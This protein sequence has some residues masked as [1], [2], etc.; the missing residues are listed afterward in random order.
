[1]P[2]GVQ[3]ATAAAAPVAQWAWMPIAAMIAPV[4]LLLLLVLL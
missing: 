3:A 2:A 1:M 4:A